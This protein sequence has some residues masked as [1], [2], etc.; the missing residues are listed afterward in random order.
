MTLPVKPVK[1]IRLGRQP[2][3]HYQKAT[4]LSTHFK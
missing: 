1:T 3:N 4:G 2:A